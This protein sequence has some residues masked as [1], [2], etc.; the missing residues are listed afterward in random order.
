MSAPAIARR[1]CDTRGFERLSNAALGAFLKTAFRLHGARFITHQCEIPE[2]KGQPKCGEGTQNLPLG[3]VLALQREALTLLRMQGRSSNNPR[4]DS[5]CCG[6]AFTGRKPSLA[7]AV[8][9]GSAV[10]K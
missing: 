1:N 3:L 2:G 4:A 6:G 7:S 10:C 5:A 8:V 9:L